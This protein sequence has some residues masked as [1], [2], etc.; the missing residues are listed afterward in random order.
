MRYVKSVNIGFGSLIGRT[1]Y[2]IIGHEEGNITLSDDEVIPVDRIRFSDYL[3]AGI[4]R[5]NIY[6]VVIKLL[7]HEALLHSYIE[8]VKTVFVSPE[9]RDADEDLGVICEGSMIGTG[10]NVWRGIK[11]ALNTTNELIEAIGVNGSVILRTDSPSDNMPRIYNLFG[12]LT[13]LCRETGLNLM[14]YK[15]LRLYSPGRGYETI[16]CFDQSI[17]ARR[18]FTK[19]YFAICR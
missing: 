2:R 8:L 17:E 6:G 7:P 5:D 3:G 16:I 15:Q 9:F 11:L 4:T 14:S 13:Q 1:R 19:M 10:N 18:F 12:L